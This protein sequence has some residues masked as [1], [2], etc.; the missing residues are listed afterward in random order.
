MENLRE[1]AKRGAFAILQE[2]RV[3]AGRLF[4]LKNKFG[5]TPCA[6]ETVEAVGVGL[7][8]FFILGQCFLWPVHL[9]KHV[10]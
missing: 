1:G 4:R 3:K 8:G 9:Q 6:L 2:L 5:G 10:G 7:Q